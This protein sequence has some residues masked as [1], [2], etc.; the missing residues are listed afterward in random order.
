MD[1]GGVNKLPKIL[2]AEKG[3]STYNISYSFLCYTNKT[4]FH[5]PKSE[6]ELISIKI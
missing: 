6:S 1:Y 4:A 5:N 3:L 2:W